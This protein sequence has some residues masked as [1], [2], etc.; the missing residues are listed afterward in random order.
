[1]LLHE[2]RFEEPNKS[3]IG[4]WKVYTVKGK[5]LYKGSGVV[6]IFWDHVNII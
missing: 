2:K 3:R 6:V 1:M 4:T 5:A